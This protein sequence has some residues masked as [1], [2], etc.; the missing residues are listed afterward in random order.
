[1]YIDNACAL[2]TYWYGNTD[3]E[4]DIIEY[5]LD[6]QQSKYGYIWLDHLK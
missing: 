2:I 4:Q 5:A 1:M 6:V 3:I